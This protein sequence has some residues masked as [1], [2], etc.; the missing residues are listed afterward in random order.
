ML[1]TRRCSVITCVP[2]PVEDILPVLLCGLFALDPPVSR[3][4]SHE[5]WLLSS[6]I[7]TLITT[8]NDVT[9]MLQQKIAA[10]YDNA[11]CSFDYQMDN[12]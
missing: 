7:L 12:E 8:V 10:D 3:T 6:W 11:H 4:D 2:L 1:L 9:E 5:E